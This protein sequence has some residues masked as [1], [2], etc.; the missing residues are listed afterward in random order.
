M[1]DFILDRTRVMLRFSTNTRVFYGVCRSLTN[2]FVQRN[3]STSSSNVALEP[4]A[5]K[6]SIFSGHIKGAITN[7]LEFIRPESITPIP[8]YQV[9]DADGKIKEESHTPDVRRR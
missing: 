5:S 8:I 3:Q 7:N 9:L 6:M 2:R 4:N 1:T